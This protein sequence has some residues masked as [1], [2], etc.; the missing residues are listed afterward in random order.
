MPAQPNEPA[1]SVLLT[2]T[3]PC[4]RKLDRSSGIEQQFIGCGAKRRNGKQV[5]DSLEGGHRF[6]VFLAL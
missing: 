1:V 3:E 6:L 2:N 5:V 4:S